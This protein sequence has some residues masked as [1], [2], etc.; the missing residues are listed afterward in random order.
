MP[1]VRHCVGIPETGDASLS[2]VSGIPLGK[3]EELVLGEGSM[4]RRE[5]RVELPMTR[6]PRIR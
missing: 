4:T 5:A 2:V 1:A 3:G 6:V